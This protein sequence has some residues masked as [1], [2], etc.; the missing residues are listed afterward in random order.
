M[1]DE[2]YEDYEHSKSGEESA[3][4][5]KRCHISVDQLEIRH[6]CKDFASER[7]FCFTFGGHDFPEH[8]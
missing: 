3:R 7:L 8:T 2:D 1:E 6:K 5:K 4:S